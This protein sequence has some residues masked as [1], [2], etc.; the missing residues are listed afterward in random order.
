[1]KLVGLMC[2]RSEDW[3][4]G[5]SLRA[6]LGW[7][8]EVVIVDHNSADGTFDIINEVS[9]D[10]PWRIHYSLW[11][12]M[13]EKELT[14]QHEGSRTLLHAHPGKSWT[15]QVPSDD[16]SKW[17]EMT[18][19][20]HSLLLGRKHGGTH[21]A[22]IDADEI[23]TA[24][25][26]DRVREDVRTLKP[27]EVLDYPLYA[28]RTLDEYQDD[29]TEWSR[30]V[31]STVFMDAPGISWRPAMDG[32]HFHARVPKGCGKRVTPVAWKDGGVMHLQFA[33]RRR[34]VAKHCWYRMTETIRYPGRNTAEQ[35]NTKYD[36]ALKVPKHLSVAP[37]EWWGNYP[38]DLIA[39]SGWP[40]HEGEIYKMI[41]KYGKDAFSG[42]DLK[43]LA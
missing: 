26:I 42:L 12:P 25:L 8:D 40:W 19:R 24:N 20:E 11:R 2:V 16:E 3:I 9:R 34:L 31:M 39:L 14:S 30:G 10:N 41:Q 32:Y 4:L 27:G 5:A 1:M 37:L 7:C 28:M 36:N 23:L 13:E 22:M 21:F 18:M 35:L 15:A 29:D 33:N 43:G 38:R 6:A 17:D